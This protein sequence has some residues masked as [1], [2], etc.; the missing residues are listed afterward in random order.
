MSRL[1]KA[2]AAWLYSA[3]L[4]ASPFLVASSAMSTRLAGVEPLHLLQLLHGPVEAH[5]GLLLVGDD[6]GRLLLEPPVLLLGLH[7][8]LL[9]LD[10]R[11]GVLVELPGEQG[12]HVVAHA[13]EE[14]DHRAPR[15]LGRRVEWSAPWRPAEA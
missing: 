14:L 12:G 1:A 7:D 3:A 4:A 11:V 15:G 13:A 2:S 10:L 5:L 9:E 6:V 8:G